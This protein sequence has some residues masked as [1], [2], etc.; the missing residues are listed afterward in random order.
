[1]INIRKNLIA[2]NPGETAVPVS[3][4]W[5]DARDINREDISRLSEDY[6][7]M[8]DFLADILDQD[9]QSRIEREDEYTA[10]II[11]LPST[12]EEDEGADQQTMPLGVVIFPDKVITICQNDNGILEDFARNRLRK[13]PIDT[14]EGFVLSILGRAAM[15]FIRMLKTYNRKKTL[16]E[17]RL[18]GAVHNDE[19]IQL[20]DIE[21]S[22]VYFTT[23]L[24]TDEMLLEKLQKT[25]YFIMNNEDERDFLEDIITDYKQAITM[26]RIYSDLINRT[27]DA[28]A[29]VISNNMNVIIKRLTV[30][31]LALMFPTFITSFYGMNISLPFDHSP[32]AWLYLAGFC[33]LVAMGGSYFISDRRNR[34]II[35]SNSLDRKERK[36]KKKEDKL[37]K[38]ARKGN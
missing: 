8:S 16:V 33:C 23:S 19:L 25:P 12:E 10:L 31:S 3:Y 28:F 27:M 13:Y 1:M 29:S 7:I 24:T 26:S 22:L 17:D 35:E 4:D 6:G 14:K 5:V 34:R 37:R 36:K 15:V 21:Q 30:I 20:L 2:R 32:F 18:Q 38:K 11:R 9:E